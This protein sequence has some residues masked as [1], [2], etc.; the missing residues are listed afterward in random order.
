[1]TKNKISISPSSQEDLLLEL[2]DPCM[3][4]KDGK[5]RAQATARLIY[6]PGEPGKRE[7]ECKGRFPFF[8]PLGPVE[9]EELSWYLERYSI[10]PTGVFKQRADKVEKQLAVWGKAIY[11]AVLDND[12]V[13]QVLAAWQGVRAGTG[14]QFTVFVDSQWVTGTQ[15]E[16][17]VE[18]NEAAALL[19]GLP[20]EL[21]RDDTGYLFRGAKPVLVRRR[22]PNQKSFDRLVTDPPIRILL[23]SPRPEDGRVG[24]IDH[25]VSALPLVLAVESLGK[26]AE[27][28]VLS[29]ATFPAL[30]EELIR[31]QRANTPYHVVH[32]DG[33]GVFD[34]RIGLGGLCFEDPREKNKLEKRNSK[35][36][37]ARDLAAVIRDH[38]IP[39]FFLEACQ[40]ARTEDDPTASVAAALLNEGVASVVAMSHS[41]LVETA[42]RFV[43]SFYRELMTGARVGEAMLA[44]QR[45]LKADR[46]RLKIFGAGRLELEDW[47]VPVLFQEEEDPPLLTRVPSRKIT[48][49]DR[50]ALESRYGALPPEPEHDFIGRSRDLLKL[51]RLL[52][53]KPYAVVCG[54]GGEGKTTLAA[55][56]ARWLV[57]TGRFYRAVFVCL[58]NV[59]DVRTVVD[60]IGRQLVPHYSVAEYT[61]T[62]LL[63][64]ALQPVGRQLGNKRTLILLDNLESILPGMD[65]DE[66]GS[67][68]RFKAAELKVFFDLCKK[69][70]AF[71]ETRLL[72]TSREALPKPFDAGRQQV[73]LGRLDKQDAIGLVHKVMTNAGLT[74]KEDERCATQ[75]EVEALVEAVNCHARSLVLLAPYIDEFGV[76][77]TTDTVGQLMAALHKQYPDEQE[78]S[79]FA[80]VELSLRRMSPVVRRQIKPLGVFNGGGHLF[81]IG[82]VLA[83][84][85]DEIEPLVA[86]LIKIGLVELMPYGF[87]RFDP[88]LAPYLRRELTDEE[89]TTSTSRWAEAMYQL[90]VDLYEELFE[91]TQL[92]FNL[93]TLELPNLIVLLDYMQDQVAA[94]A[95]VYLATRLEQLVVP[96]C[97]PRLLARIVAIREEEAKKLTGWDHTQFVA[98]KTQIE[99]LLDGGNFP[100]ALSEAQALLKKCLHAGEDAFP[101]AAYDTAIAYALLGRVLEKKGESEMALQYIAE[102]QTRFEKL[103]GQGITEAAGMASACIA[104]KGI[105]LISLGQVEKAARA[106]EESIEHA[107]KLKDD[108]QVAVAKGQLGTVSMLQGRHDQ[109]LKIYAEARETFERLDEPAT[110]AGIWHLTGRVYEKIG[111][112]DEADSAYRQAL[113]IRVQLNIKSDE[114]ASLNQLGSLYNEMERWEEAETFCRQAVDK[115]IEI[116]DRAKEGF[117]RSN[118]ARAL[119]KLKKYA[120]ARM[121]ILRTMECIKPYGN[122]AEP[123]NAWNILHNL[124]MAEGHREAAIRARDQAIEL[125]LAYRRA[126]GENHNPGGRLCHEFLQAVQAQQTGQMATLVETLKNIS[127]IDTSFKLLIEKLQT[128]LAGSRDPNLAAD[129]D[130]DFDDA[131]EL[132]LLL[133][134]LG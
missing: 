104:E 131:A 24:Y 53:Q 29:P 130:L 73:T 46:F 32:F 39:L 92:A 15:E 72:F 48:G 47:F 64:K 40:S 50:L 83:L 102:A 51:E 79:L 30:E 27:L 113:T 133:E 71:G 61:P 118:L 63:T 38:R 58:E 36:I 97:R 114:A 57:R 120:D 77:Q 82:Q 21:L 124:E 10:W 115:Y 55:E 66:A 52:E 13:R 106:Y 84:N 91:D 119:I 5:K 37:D 74:P 2:T 116:N 78:R 126:G 16:K 101:E 20:W 128:I 23:I 127:D 111:Q 88:A 1:M 60:Q 35:I 85:K 14:R 9:S 109:A 108:R 4:E 59:Y 94:E 75:P 26:L 12:S 132:Q 93:T 90:S 96:L 89:L 122:A 41:V 42:R 33:H 43:E 8:A 117:A 81:V 86:E 99:R 125:F 18:A 105:S 6:R 100:G 123:W 22:L 7:V 87:L 28:T 3:V 98:L 62:E 19:L 129:P 44:G 31:A 49:I 17:Q 134:Q 54:Q 45:A 11:D 103:A 69:L 70:L 80:S 67:M 95:T 34:R 65:G 107:I 110:V 56:L 112:W 25:R 76:G 121:E 68:A